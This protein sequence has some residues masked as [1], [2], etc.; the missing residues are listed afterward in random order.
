MKAALIRY[1]NRLELLPGQRAQLRA[2]VLAAV[3]H[4]DRREFRAD[5]R[6]ARRLDASEFRRALEERAKDVE[7][8]VRR[9]ARW[10]LVALDQRAIRRARRCP[11]CEQA[12]CN[13][14]NR[15]AIAQRATLHPV[16]GAR[17]RRGGE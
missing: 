14:T 16:W 3:D 11:V 12:Q 4:R 10:V 6:L 9:R 1:I 17:C 15:F 5:G 8:R 2:V 13:C 7:P